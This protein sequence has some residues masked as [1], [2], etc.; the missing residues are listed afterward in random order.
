[1]A[2]RLFSQMWERPFSA[3]SRLLHLAAAVALAALLAP[4]LNLKGAHV[5]NDRT[6]NEVANNGA[7]LL[8]RRRLDAQ[9]RLRRVLQD[10]AEG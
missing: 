1:M 4:T 8:L 3:K 9:P 6:L 5:S 10:H 2:S 7:A